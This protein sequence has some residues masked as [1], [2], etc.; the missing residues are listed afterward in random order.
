MAGSEFTA[1]LQALSHRLRGDS[2]SVQGLVRLSGGASQET[3]A[4]DIHQDGKATPLI[5]RRAPGGIAPARSSEAI[6]LPTEAALI[7]IA[8]R[9]GAPV[10]EIIH[11][12]TPD[13]NLG[14]AVIMGR[15]AGETLA[16]KILR[17]AEFDAIRPSLARECGGI[18]ARIHAAPLSTLPALPHSDGL[19]QLA[20]YQTVYRDFGA[21]RPVF[22]L[23]FS[24]L[25]AHAPKPLPPTLVHGDF[26]NGNL[27]IA[28]D[29]VKAVLDWELSHIGD[30]REDLGWICVASW[31][32][33]Q[34]DSP[35]G[36][37]GTVEDLIAGYQE[38][39]GT[40]V[41]AHDIRWFEMM[42]TLKWGVMCLIMYQ[43]FASGLELSVEKAAIGRRASETEID[44]MNIFAS[45]PHA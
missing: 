29:G 4:F 11:V 44:L 36:G 26:R 28:P 19:A 23:A 35:V 1:A 2:A 45:L 9:T 20:R 33:G 21:K 31:R 34:L 14:E 17:D 3:W 10:P 41:S 8:A 43:T 37:F 5:L 24:W 42:G 18:L 22:E 30:P 39:G 40:E 12:C 27:I 13:D 16:R 7:Q 15:I 6:S 32:F 38:A 25:A